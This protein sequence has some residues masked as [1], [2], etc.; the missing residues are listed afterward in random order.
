MNLPAMDFNMCK[1][2][3]T[4]NFVSS[5]WFIPI[6]PVPVLFWLL[7]Y[8]IVKKRNKRDQW[9]VPFVPLWLSVGRC[10]KGSR[11]VL[12]AALLVRMCSL[13]VWSFS[14]LFPLQSAPCLTDAQLSSS[15]AI[16]S[17][18]QLR[19][20]D[21]LAY[22]GIRFFSALHYWPGVRVVLVCVP[23]PADFRREGVWCSVFRWSPRNVLFQS[24]LGEFL[25]DNVMLFCLVVRCMKSSYTHQYV[26]L[27]WFLLTCKSAAM[28]LVHDCT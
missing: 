11:I 21:S 9:T 12:F 16:W 4:K 1:A 24:L 10:A 23:S 2:I 14:A 7:S 19:Q 22:P 26:L 18:V 17:T 6:P 27:L 8:H 15:C 3:V 28:G 20:L 5:N 25:D 13:A